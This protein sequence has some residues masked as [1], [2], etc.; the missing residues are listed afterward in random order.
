MVI[1]TCNSGSF[2]G[3][4]A[5]EDCC[6]TV[7]QK[8][9]AKLLQ[10]RKISHGCE[11]YASHFSESTK[12]KTKKYFSTS[13][14]GRATSNL[15]LGQDCRAGPF[16]SGKMLPGDVQR[17]QTATFSCTASSVPVCGSSS[18][19]CVIL[20]FTLRRLFNQTHEITFSW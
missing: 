15:A 3:L 20:Q 18:F 8:K 11:I 9:T 5:D 10:T 13:L 6:Y 16:P 1:S 2:R 7:I 19:K 17:P 14:A 4:P 12:M